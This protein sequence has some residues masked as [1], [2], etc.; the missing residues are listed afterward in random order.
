MESTQHANADYWITEVRYGRESKSKAA[1]CYA[2]GAGRTDQVRSSPFTTNNIF[3]INSQP[4]IVGFGW[5][6]K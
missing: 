4:N 5:A 3:V 6:L 1:T 2:G